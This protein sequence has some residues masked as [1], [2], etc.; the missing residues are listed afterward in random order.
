MS[1]GK[2]PSKAAID[3]WGLAVPKH[4]LPNIWA[5]DS[6]KSRIFDANGTELSESEG[7]YGGA[8]FF[9][10]V[11]TEIVQARNTKSV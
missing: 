8:R 3:G 11:A 9:V 6:S 10:Q 7:V 2:W 1:A 4:R 5:H